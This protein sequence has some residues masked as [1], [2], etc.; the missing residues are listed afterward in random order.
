MD[1]YGTY[2]TFLITKE[3]RRQNKPLSVKEIALLIRIYGSRREQSNFEKR[4]RRSIQQIDCILEGHRVGQKNIFVTKYR[5]NV[6]S[7]EEPVRCT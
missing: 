7:E 6:G 3:L 2:L 5:L 4:I 1:L